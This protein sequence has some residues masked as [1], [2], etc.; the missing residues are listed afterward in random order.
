MPAAERDDMEQARLREYPRQLRAVADD[1]L[2]RSV[3]LDQWR[4]EHFDSPDRADEA[5][6]AS[7]VADLVGGIKVA[8]SLLDAADKLDRH[9]L[10]ESEITRLFKMPPSE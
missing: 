3:N 7:S 5:A 6:L 1:I 10:P 2:R 9:S 4:K 8:V